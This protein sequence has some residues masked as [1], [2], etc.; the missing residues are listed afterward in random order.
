M[1]ESTRGTKDM[2]NGVYGGAAA[3][4]A[5]GLRGGGLV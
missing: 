5:L 1:S 4:A 2:W 3:G